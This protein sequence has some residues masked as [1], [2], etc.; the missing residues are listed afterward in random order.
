M[1]TAATFPPSWSIERSAA[2]ALANAAYDRFLELLRDLV[3]DDWGLP[4]D[5]T[6][7]TVRD[8]VAHVLGWAETTTMRQFMRLN[9]LGKPVA[10]ELG[11]PL[12]DGMNE[13]LVR[14]RASLPPSTLVE[15]LERIAPKAVTAR[16]RV[17]APLRL[18]PINTP[19][20][21]INLGY[22]NDHVFTRDLWIHRVDIGRAT[23]RE[24]SLTA[25]HDGRIVADVV[26]AWADRHRR[27]FRL[28]LEGA[29]GGVYQRGS[30]G[31]EHRL[32]AVEFCRIVS[33]RVEGTELLATRVLF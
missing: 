16:A 29:A 7:W 12:I 4:T 3:D 32:D 20:G 26:A 8:I 13:V 2:P 1:T 31:D 22:L 25:E 6:R 23:G 33:G 27:P 18:L 9:R 10:R 28:E 21:R 24:I 5:C 11:A 30:A 14:Q 19:E 17:P 15:R